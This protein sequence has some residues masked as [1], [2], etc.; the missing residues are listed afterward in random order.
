MMEVRFFF[1]IIIT[2]MTRNLFDLLQGIRDISLDSG[3][4]GRRII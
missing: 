4:T 2:E 3:F 1:I